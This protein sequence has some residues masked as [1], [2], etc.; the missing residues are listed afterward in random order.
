MYRIPVNEIIYCKDNEK[1]S[2]KFC[3]RMKDV[4]LKVSYFKINYY[5]C[6]CLR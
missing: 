5:F 3:A 4:Y 6:I 2:G 1:Q